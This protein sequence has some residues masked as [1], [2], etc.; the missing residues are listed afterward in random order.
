MR[1]SA[2]AYGVSLAAVAAAVGVRLLLEPLLADRLPF[3]TLFAAVVFVAWYCGRGPALLALVVGSF[4]VAYFILRP[5]YSFAVDQFEYQVGLVLYG[6][7][8]L[9]AV[10]MF[11]S[12]RKA[13]QRAEEKQRRLEQEVAVG[14]AAEKASA[15]REEL[16][17]SERRQAEEQF[18]V[19]AENIPQL[20][21]MARPD[22]HIFWYNRR[23]YEYTGTTPDSQEG[24]GW[25]SVH[26][27]EVLPEV[28][29]RWKQ[30][31]ATGEPFDMVFPL[32]GRD[33]AFR[34]FLTRIMPV[35]DAEGRVVQW[36]GTNTD[37][38][39]QKQ[40][41]EELRKLTAELSEADRR[42]DEF[43]ATLAHELRNPLAPIRNGLEIMRLSSGG[44]ETVEKARA[45]M[46]RQ[47]GQMV[48]L[49]DDLL[50]VS[51]ISRGKL[52]LRKERVDLAVVLNNAVETSRPLID[53]NGH[54]LTVGVPPWPIFV[55]ADVTRLG[56]VFGNLLNNAAKY[57]ERG[58]RIGLTAE[59][60][61]G[62]VVVSVKDTG[63]GIPPD[64]LP[65]IFEMFTQVDRSLEKS[66]G[67]LGIGLTLVK[68]LVEMHGGS[69][70][71][72]SDGHGR[73]SEFVVRLP[74]WKDEGG[75]MKDE[76]VIGPSGSSFILPPSSLKVLVADDNEDAASSLAI[77]L[78]I[79]G[80]EVLTAND[81]LRAVEAAEAF[82]PDVILLDIG[83]PKLN[84]YEVCRR[85]RERP[86]GVKAVLIALTGWG[87]E[88]DKRRSQ[89]A[90]FDHHMV[91][92]VDPAALEKLLAGPSEARK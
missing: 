22:G 15:E 86:W 44:G 63:V 88:E 51:R 39:E 66:Q 60:Q 80:N 84:G 13:R 10:A 19:M 92:P 57:S 87:Q 43:L 30:C 48:H 77:L 36:F 8:G 40:A 37:I 38:T 21:W 76:S 75:R 69:V 31:I 26:D 73:G 79:M 5:R 64:M 41:A 82:R 56:Q 47:L 50:D 45:M 70:E 11:D 33:G 58:G 85:I 20:A 42:K 9:A 52:D 55:D 71:A 65:K 28:R 35:K 72:K 4:A 23:W 49:V 7:V 32:K 83:M 34:P 17:V 29:E 46:E 1:P 62:E 78:K 2:A 68:Q 74:L 90:G 59:R 54:E 27:P 67:G 89:E 25:E 91:K 6:V 81:G 16:H 53:S 3:V 61:G 24:W 12:L 14:R 18:R